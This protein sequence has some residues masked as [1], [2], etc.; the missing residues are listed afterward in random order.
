[1]SICKVEARETPDHLPKKT[2][3]NDV[4]PPVASYD[5]GPCGGYPSDPQGWLFDLAT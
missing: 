1:M 2:F 3:L 5:F 4:G